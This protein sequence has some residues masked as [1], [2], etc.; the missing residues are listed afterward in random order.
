VSIDIDARVVQAV[1][2]YWLTRSRQSQDQ[3]ARGATD[4]GQRG[5]ATAGAHMGGFEALVVDALAEEGLTDMEVFTSAVLKDLRLTR[6]PARRQ[7]VDGADENAVV[8]REK[9][10]LQLPGYFRPEKRWDLLVVSRKRLVAA[11]EFKSMNSSFGNNLNNRAE[12]SVGSAQDL[13]T[14]YRE[15]L[16]GSDLRRPLLGYFFLLRDCDEVHQPV[17]NEEPH[18][19]VDEE[20][21]D[22][23]YSVRVELLCR[24]LVLERLYDT[25]CLI[26]ATEISAE[27]P[28]SRYRFPADLNIH[29]FIADIR[30]HARRFIDT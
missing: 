18:F 27:A 22:A 2:D 13:W 1:Q 24:R 23:S 26:L 5:S 25:A 3:A 10:G 14:A 16:L 7:A 9:L 19:Q 29:R 15:G 11:L 8:V 28:Q 4:T 20:F 6:K 17:G 30:A 21:R 12:E